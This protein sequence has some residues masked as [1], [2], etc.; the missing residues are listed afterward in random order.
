[1][2]NRTNERMESEQNQIFTSKEA[3]VIMGRLNI[4]QDNAKV[5]NNTHNSKET[6]KARMYVQDKIC[7]K[8]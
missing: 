6:P 7:N 5:Q 2:V 1:M 3:T 8:I 4:E